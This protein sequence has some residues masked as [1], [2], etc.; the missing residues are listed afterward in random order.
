MESTT[1]VLFIGDVIGKKGRR[2][3][4]AILPDLRKEKK[5]DLVIANGENTAGGFGINKK[6]ADEL[7]SGGVDIITGGN[8]IFS[9]KEVYEIIEEYPIIRPANYPPA[10]P[11]RGYIIKNG[12]CVI[13][14]CGR[15]FMEPLDCPFRAADSIINEVSEKTKIIII[16]I[17]AEAT[18]EK[19]AMG[20]YL[21]G[22]VSAV[23][24]THTHIQTADARLLP[25]STAYITDVGMVGARDSVIGMKKATILK[26]F[27]TQIPERF[28]T[29]KEDGIF[30]AVVLEIDI[31]SGYS[32]SITPIKIEEIK[33]I[34]GKNVF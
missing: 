1:R 30:C 12:L 27:L 33:G 31:E 22:R 32:L 9:K 13:S 17:H 5:I 21:D 20:W 10:V 23:I 3:V 28:E 26:K 11:G 2:L 18:S 6:T 7:L 15:V 25:K 4:S 34:G 24:G 19:V 14:L 8:H 29:A 16:D